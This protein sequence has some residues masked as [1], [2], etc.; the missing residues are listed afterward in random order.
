[1][2][3]NGGASF[4]ACP[5][6]L[7]RRGPR[8]DCI[9]VLVLLSFLYLQC[10]ARLVPFWDAPYLFLITSATQIELFSSSSKEVPYTLD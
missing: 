7:C 9:P 5:L 1:M 6:P 8:G 10:L 2:A 4:P 3:L